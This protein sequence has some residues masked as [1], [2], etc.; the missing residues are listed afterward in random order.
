MDFCLG[1]GYACDADVCFWDA[2]V[3]CLID[4]GFQRA[5]ILQ[6]KGSRRFYKVFAGFVIGFGQH[7]IGHNN[8][9]RGI[10]FCSCICIYSIS[11]NKHYKRIILFGFAAI[12][13]WWKLKRAVRM[14]A[15]VHVHQFQSFFA[16]IFCN[17]FVFL[18]LKDI[19]NRVYVR[20]YG[21][22]WHQEVF[23]AF[24]GLCFYGNIDFP[25]VA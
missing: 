23:S 12:R 1:H 6:C 20:F 17:G 15:A 7:G 19:G 2:A 22:V 18:D 21:P 10:C 16:G 3:I 11:G 13:G 25:A 9:Q 24:C 5:F 4:G 14:K 8:I